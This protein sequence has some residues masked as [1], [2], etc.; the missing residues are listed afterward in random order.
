EHRPGVR[1]SPRECLSPRPIAP[2]IAHS[3]R[4]T[5]PGFVFSFGFDRLDG[6]IVCC[7]RPGGRHRSARVTVYS[8]RLRPRTMATVAVS[9][10][11]AVTTGGGGGGATGRA[12]ASSSGFL[13]T[14]ALRSLSVTRRLG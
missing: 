1:A 7:F 3:P 6:S 9:R 4:L 2:S 14:K 11:G 12:G 8:S 5:S 10:G 13:T